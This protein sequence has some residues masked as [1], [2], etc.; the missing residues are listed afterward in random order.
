MGSR[1]RSRGR[2]PWPSTGTISSHT[3]GTCRLASGSRNLAF[4]ATLSDLG[5]VE[6]T[7]VAKRDRDA[8][9]EN[10]AQSALVQVTDR[11]R[12][13]VLD[14]RGDSAV[15]RLLDS[16]AIPFDLAAK[17]PR[18]TALAQYDQLILAGVPLDDLTASDATAIELYVTNLGG[19][20]LVIQGQDEVRGLTS[21]P[22]DGLLPVTFTVP[23]TERDPSLAM[24]YILDRSGSMSELV[25]ARAKIR[26]LREATAASV[27]VLPPDTLVGVVG[28]ADTTSWLFP[29]APVGNAEA[30]YQT[31]QGLRAGGGT[32]LYYPVRDAVDALVG[33]T[34]R[35]KHILLVSDGKTV[36]DARDYPGL[37]LDIAKTRGPHGIGHRPRRRA[38]PRTP[39]PARRGR[40]RRAVPSR[41]LPRAAAGRRRHHPAT[42]TEPLRCR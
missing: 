35:V 19:G 22:I 12:V 42:R 27:F 41:R 4:A 14:P 34:A 29:L 32:D 40:S 9:P 16:L 25:D 23:E 7:A 1:R 30:V 18:I 33:T 37:I 36:A 20:L 39:R 6:Y 5:A 3:T 28:F 15:P 10:D 38:E 2:P 21:S 24:V 26:I 13:L 8:F 11:A 31:L 17:M